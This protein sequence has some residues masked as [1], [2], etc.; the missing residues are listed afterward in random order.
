[1]PLCVRVQFGIWAMLLALALVFFALGAFGP[2][3]VA[4]LLAQL[5]PDLVARKVKP[6]PGEDRE[7]VVRSSEEG[8]D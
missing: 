2:P 7:G 5:L 3:L 6:R 8:S 4:L 1:M